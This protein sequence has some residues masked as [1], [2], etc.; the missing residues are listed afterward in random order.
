MDIWCHDVQRVPKKKVGLG[1]LKK[2]NMTTCSAVQSVWVSGK[3][4]R[5]LGN[6]GRR[7]DRALPRIS[8]SLGCPGQAGQLI[9]DESKGHNWQFE[10]LRKV[11]RE[12]GL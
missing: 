5:V 7:K 3:V 10:F 1:T 12:L 2:R 11:G 8:I 4:D 9:R 6:L